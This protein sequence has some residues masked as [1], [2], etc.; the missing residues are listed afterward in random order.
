[1]RRLILT[2]AVAFA[3]CHVALAGDWPQVLGPHRNGIAHD[4]KLA[5]KWPA[6][7]PKTL[8]QRPVGDGFAGA[9]IVGGVAVVWH[10]QR[11]EHVIES[12][13]VVSGDVN[14]TK[15]LPARYVP[16][17]TRDSGP[18]VVPLI[19]DGRRVS[20]LSARRSVL[21]GTEKRRDA[22]APRYV[23]RL[24]QQTS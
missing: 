7:G 15:S 2:A 18:R 13:N 14:W 5:D 1:M 12:L 11:N 8:W 20:V 3:C 22:L 17:Y 10:R 9:S 6:S 24:Q 16:S 21:P 4:E 23:G 19:N